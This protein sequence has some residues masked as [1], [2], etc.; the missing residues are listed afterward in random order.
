ML[1]QVEKVKLLGLEFD[2]QLSFNVHIDSLYK[3]IVV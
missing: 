1:G 3:K 2:E